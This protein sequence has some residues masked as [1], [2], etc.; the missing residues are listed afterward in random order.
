[1]ATVFLALGSNVGDS[2]RHIEKAVELLGGSVHNITRAP[3]YTSKAFGVTNQPDFVNTALRGETDL[4]PLALLAFVKN[5][6][7]KVGRV[8]RYRWGPREIDIDIIFYDDLVLTD[9]MLTIPHAGL[10]ERDFVLRPLNDI[11]PT[12]IDP[13]SKRSVRELLAKLSQDEAYILRRV[14]EPNSSDAKPN[15]PHTGFPHL[16]ERKR[17]VVFLSVMLTL[18]IGVVAGGIVYNH[19]QQKRITEENNG[20]SDALT[21]HITSSDITISQDH[22]VEVHA[23]IRNPADYGIEI[24]CGYQEVYYIDGHALN[25]ESKTD[26]LSCSSVGIN[27]EYNPHHNYSHTFSI[28]PSTYAIGK[29]SFYVLYNGHRSNKIHITITKARS[30][31]NCYAFTEYPTPLCS[32][33][34][35]RDQGRFFTLEACQAYLQYLRAETPIRPII[36]KRGSPA[37]E[38][39]SDNVYRTH[40]IT[41]NV[42]QSDPDHWISKLHKKYNYNANDGGALAFVYTNFVMNAYPLP[43]LDDL[44]SGSE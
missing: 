36:T 27:A 28:N 5:V 33:I 35:L 13:L 18:M 21:M 7:A 20:S 30:I 14:A 17:L 12:Y 8:K 43:S 9:P 22:Y 42:P 24:D 39:G 3:L 34:Q 38:I 44:L 6:E 26:D 23:E 41:A 11:D 40:K 2:R 31:K 16:S 1:M 10:R 19:V 4:A 37:C 32:Q 25:Y 15:K 29:H